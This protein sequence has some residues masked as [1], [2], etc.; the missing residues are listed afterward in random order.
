MHKRIGIG[1]VMAGA[2]AAALL[3][4]LGTAAAAADI[5]EDAIED[6]KEGLAPVT[7]LAGAA[8]AILGVG[9]CA[10]AGAAT[11]AG[12][13]ATA[14][15]A[16]GGTIGVIATHRAN[17]ELD[18]TANQPSPPLYD[19]EWRPGD[20]VRS[21]GGVGATRAGTLSGFTFPG[22]VFDGVRSGSGGRLQILK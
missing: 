20:G 21:G 14:G 2:I 8:G 10:L 11:A 1:V 16:L 22:G 19:K 9:T 17:R 15:G 18:R 4:H 5:D 6:A 13:C 12:L 7:P 3:I